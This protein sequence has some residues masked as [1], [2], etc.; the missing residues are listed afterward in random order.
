MI[1]WTFRASGRGWKTRRIVASWPSAT[2]VL[3]GKPIWADRGE[4]VGVGPASGSVDTVKEL[5]VG[6]PNVGAKAED[7]IEDR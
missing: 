4:A 5:T 1:V 2:A 7:A 6:G 3:P